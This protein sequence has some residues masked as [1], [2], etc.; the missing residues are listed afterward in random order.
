MYAFHGRRRLKCPCV[1]VNKHNVAYGVIFMSSAVSSM[2]YLPDL[3]GLSEVMLVDEQL[4]FH[5][6]LLPGFVQNIL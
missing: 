2:S 3:D 4:L 6:V 5:G 1:G